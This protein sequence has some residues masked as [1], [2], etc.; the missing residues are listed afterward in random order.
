MLTQMYNRAG[1]YYEA[2][3]ILEIMKLQDCKIFVLFS[4]VD[5]L[6]KINDTYGHEAG[7]ELIKEMAACFKENLS[8][9]MLAMRYGGDEF[10]VFGSYEKDEE[11]DY[12]LQAIQNSMDLRNA[13]GK[14]VFKLS[15]SIGVSKYDAKEIGELSELIDIAD[16]NM[17][18]QKRK[19]RET[20]ED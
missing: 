10:V 2:K 9:D 1:F 15:A 3:T 18:E 16:A 13:T 4:D 7:D 5:G 8:N 6:K 14:Y 17:Y 19:K 11:V 12:L 20:R